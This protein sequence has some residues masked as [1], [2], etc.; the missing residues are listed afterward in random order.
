MAFKAVHSFKVIDIEHLWLQLEVDLN[1]LNI[2]LK[3]NTVMCS[4]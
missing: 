4:D 1:L 3:A 2:S